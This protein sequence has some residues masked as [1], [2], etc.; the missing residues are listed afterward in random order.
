MIVNQM[1]MVP[2]HHLMQQIKV[3]SQQR[4][5]TKFKHILHVLAHWYNMVSSVIL[6]SK[7]RSKGGQVGAC[8]PGRRP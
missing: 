6:Q 7:W 2:F 1:I 5:I 8:A 4:S 3:I